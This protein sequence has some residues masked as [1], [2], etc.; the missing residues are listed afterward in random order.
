L[1]SLYLRMVDR[2]DGRDPAGWRC[3][4]A[5][6]P[7]ACVS[8]IPCWRLYYCGAWQRAAVTRAAYERTLHCIES[9]GERCAAG[10][11]FNPC[12]HELSLVGESTPDAGL[13]H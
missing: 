8:G 13:P 11:V 12:G 10:L 1:R 6:Q 2:E 5:A 9:A 7:V 4:N 3:E